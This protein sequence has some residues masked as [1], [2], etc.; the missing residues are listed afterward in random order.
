M[1]EIN[2]NDIIG[3]SITVLPILDNITWVKN[4]YKMLLNENPNGD[5]KLNLLVYEN[6][7]QTP[8]GSTTLKINNDDCSIKYGSYDL[9]IYAYSGSQEE[10]VSLPLGYSLVV[11]LNEPKGVEAKNIAKIPQPPHIKNE[12][13]QDKDMFDHLPQPNQDEE[14]KIPQNDDKTSNDP[15]I[16]NTLKQHQ[17]KKFEKEELIV[18]YIDTARFLPESISLSR[19]SIRI[20]TDQGKVVVAPQGTT[21]SLKNSTTENPVFGYRLEISKKTHPKLNATAV[22]IITMETIDRVS[23]LQRVVGY[24]YFPL[25]V[26]KLTGEPSKNEASSEYCLN[27]GCYQLP[28]YC[29]KPRSE[30][31]ITFTKLTQAERIPC[32][33]LLIRVEKAPKDASGRPIFYEGLLQKDAIEKGVLTLPPEY[34]EGK[35][36]NKY[37]NLDS[38]ELTIYKHKNERIDLDIKD[39]LRIMRDL[40]LKDKKFSKD[41]RRKVRKKTNDDISDLE[42]LLHWFAD[43]SHS[44]EERLDLNY[45]SQFISEIGFKFGVEMIF[46][47]DPSLIY[48]WLCSLNPPGSMYNK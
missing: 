24:C 16:P 47:W 36:S 37:I 33:T 27:N 34:N 21:C 11:I 31:P 3:T 44:P 4:L 2:A 1:R 15:F 28:L 26:D 32:S 23:L 9:P 18:F 10:N 8:T 7:S 38:D 19:V 39:T 40:M 17:N 48:V 22:A 20:I 45:F 42:F 5:L 13:P 14:E 6:N 35:Y 41:L 30:L 43:F 25:F 12:E 29:D 46:N